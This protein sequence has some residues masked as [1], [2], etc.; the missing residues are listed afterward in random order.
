[1]GNTRSANPSL[2]NNGVQVAML[3]LSV[4]LFLALAGWVILLV[5][6][7]NKKSGIHWL[8]SIV[9]SLLSFIGWGVIGGF[10][11]APVLI[12]L[13]QLPFGIPEGIAF[14]MD[15]ISRSVGVVL[16]AYLVFVLNS[17]MVKLEDATIFRRVQ[18]IFSLAAISLCLISASTLLTWVAVL[19]VFDLM[20]LLHLL[21]Q[22][23]EI[24][25][26][27]RYFT[28]ALISLAGTLVFF[29]GWLLSIHTS[30]ASVVSREILYAGL[31]I[32]LWGGF[33]RLET[34]KQSGQSFVTFEE[35]L[36]FFVPLFT[37]FMRFPIGSTLPNWMEYLLGIGIVMMGYHLVQ[38][39]RSTNRSTSI[40]HFY[41]FQILFLLVYIQAGTVPGIVAMLFCFLLSTVVIFYRPIPHRFYLWFA[42][43]LFALLIGL[44]FLPTSNLLTLRDP[45]YNGIF[46]FY[47]LFLLGI[48]KRYETNQPSLIVFERW[49]K[50]LYPIAYLPFLSGLVYLVLMR[51]IPIQLGAFILSGG[52]GVILL[53]LFIYNQ[54]RRKN[55][56]AENESLQ[57]IKPVLELLWSRIMILVNQRW[58]ERLL[59][60]IGALIK[61]ILDFL[62]HIMEGD[63]AL[64]WAIVL[65]ILFLSIVRH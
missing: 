10:R 28:S 54:L 46:V 49:M 19:I 12:D 11:T 24:E 53:I 37:F 59:Q 9:V 20:D 34:K 60:F 65:L 18:N 16:L 3:I 61:R 41:A 48:W 14:S 45:Q 39:L 57:W 5:H 23:R 15:T 26:P 51:D 22:I 36:F 33:Y 35:L 58:I 42:F 55:I 6:R 8:I 44:P 56:L 7:L 2:F 32:H 64:L 29:L 30:A 1:M 43:P 40:T 25:S 52:L 47:F 17:W 31:F 27:K 50:V 38:W 13:A 4:P 62:N 63:G 21:R